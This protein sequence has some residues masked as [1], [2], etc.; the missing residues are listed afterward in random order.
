MGKRCAASEGRCGVATM[1]GPVGEDA[2][3][4]VRRTLMENP[5]GKQVEM[6]RLASRSDARLLSVVGCHGSGKDWAT[7]RLA[8]W[9]VHSRSPAK[10]VVTGPSLRQVK[11]VVWREMRAA[12]GKAQG[13]LGGRMLK[14]RYELSADTFAV[15]FTSDSPHKILGYHSPNLL[16]VVT[17]AHAVSDEYINAV[18]RLN[19]SL[20]VMTG[21]PFVN[22]GVF[23]DS[24]HGE[25]GLW[26]TVEIGAGDIPN[27]QREDEL[28]AGMMTQRD[29][30]DRMADWGEDSASYIGGVL[31]EF[32]D[33]PDEA[34]VP[35]WAVKAAIGRGLEAE[36][37]L[38]VACDVARKGKA[39]TVVARRQGGAARIVYRKR[40]SD[41]M[42]TANWLK[43]YCDA[44]RA[45]ILVVDDVGVGG[46]VTDRVR[47]KG[48]ET[49]QVLEFRGGDPA[50]Q[51]S[52]FH[53]WNAEVWWAMR[54][55]YLEGEMSMGNEPNLIGQLTSRGYE[56]DER[57]R[58][59]LESKRGMRHSPDE[60]D[61]LAMTFAVERKRGLGNPLRIWV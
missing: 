56:L 30:D 6:L 22:D 45:D 4:F 15:G 27:I 44:E 42:Q 47:E 19:P 18:R 50:R 32:A 28:S 20:L 5:H 26:N 57:G 23:Y 29:V 37:E 21:N 34:I 24:H 1:E 38:V 31:G 51:K 33:D 41:T 46:G 59:K 7:A 16:A 39:H 25:R 14:M 9:W 49:A 8:L 36:G 60:A 35:L 13:R 52:R 3:E 10:V 58:V 40:G 2:V 55:R 54:V 12:Y 48:L 53:D 17:E 11:D 61:A 43:N